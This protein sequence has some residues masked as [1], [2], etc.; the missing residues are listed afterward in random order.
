MDKINRI[1]EQNRADNGQM[2]TI[3]DYEG[4]HNVTIQFE[5]GTVVY[6]KR[7]DYFKS[8]YIVN[9]N[10]RVPPKRSEDLIGETKVAN[11]GLKMTIIAARTTCD[12]DI[13]FENGVI[14][15]HK[16]YKEFKAGNIGCPNIGK[17]EDIASKRVGE[18]N[19]ANNGQKMTIIEYR[20]SEDIDIQFEDGTIVK[21][22]RYRQFKQGRIKNS[23]YTYQDKTCDSFIGMTT[24]AKNGL[25]MTIIAYRKHNDIDIQFEDG[26]IVK[27]KQLLHFRQG[28]I[29]HPNINLH[30]KS[31]HVGEKNTNK[32]GISMQIQKYVT[33]RDIDIKFETGFISEHKFYNNFLT[34]RIGHPFP[35]RLNNVSIDNPAY[36][37]NNI[38][39]FYCHCTKC[40]KKDIMTI[41]EIKQHKCIKGDYHNGI[42]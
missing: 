23:N 18:T 37:Y 26:V 41:E 25:R 30:I 11:N 14:V 19:T 33:C 36:I 39:N 9:P 29:K 15:E 27:H 31:F 35:Y 38:G 10:K 8:G 6:K 20:T 2:M 1:G 16:A 21:H 32:A 42:K 4:N 12:I 24:K 34:G 13:R 17:Y 5:D 28:A 40:G 22:T 3:I 7:Y